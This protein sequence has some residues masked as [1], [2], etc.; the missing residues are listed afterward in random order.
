[1]SIQGGKSI[2]GLTALNPLVGTEDFVVRSA[3]Q[4]FRVNY[5]TLL[6]K[7]SGDLTVSNTMTNEG[8]LIYFTTGANTRLPIGT[9]NQFLR[10]SSGL[11]IW[12]T[13][14]I[15]TNPTTFQGD[16]I[17]NE[18]GELQ[19]V[20]IGSAGQVLTVGVTG[21]PEWTDRTSYED[22]LTTTGDILIRGDVITERLAAGVEGQ[23]LTMADGKPAWET[24]SNTILFANGDLLTHNGDV[25]VVLGIGTEGQFLTVENSLPAW[26][27]VT[28]Y[29]DPLTTNGD[30]VARI[31]GVTTRLG[32]GTAGQV[33]ASTG[34][35]PEWQD[36]SSAILI[37]DLLPISPTASNPSAG[38]DGQVIF[39][40]ETVG[41]Y[42]LKDEAGA[43]RIFTNG[44]S[45]VN[46]VVSIGGTT[47]D[48]IEL[49]LNQSN[50]LQLEQ[51]TN[52][53]LE[54]GWTGSY[55]SKIEASPTFIE[56]LH[57]GSYGS[58]ARYSITMNSSTK[59]ML[60]TDGVNARGIEYAADY[61]SKFTNETLVTRRYVNNEFNRIIPMSVTALNPGAGQ[62]GYVL[63]WDN[64]NEVFDLKADAG[65]A[66]SVSI[67]GTPLNNQLAVWTSASQIEGDANLLWNGGSLDITGDLNVDGITISGQSISS[68]G[69]LILSPAGGIVEI[70]NVTWNVGQSLGPAQDGYVLTYDD[71]TGTAFFD[72]VGGGGAVS[73]AGTPSANEIAV[74]TNS[75]TI[76]GSTGF[77]FDA[78][79][80]VLSIGNVKIDND[81]IRVGLGVNTLTLNLTGGLSESLS[82]GAFI[83]L[84]GATAASSR[85]VAIH[86]STIDFRIGTSGVGSVSASVDSGGDWNF[87]SNNIS[88]VGVLST[89][90]L[91]IGDSGSLSES[92]GKLQ[93]FHP[94]GIVLN[95]DGNLGIDFSN[96]T[97]FNIDSIS[98]GSLSLRPGEVTTSGGNLVIGSLTGVVE[99][100]ENTLNIGDTANSST[101]VIQAAGSTATNN[102]SIQPKGSGNVSIGNYTFDGDQ[103]VGA[104]QDGYTMTYSNSTGLVSLSAQNTIG[105]PTSVLDG[106]GVT[107][108]AGLNMDGFTGATR[109]FTYQRI[110]N[111]VHFNGTAG[112][113]P[114]ATGL[115]NFFI[116]MP[117]SSNFSQTYDAGGVCTAKGSVASG[118][119]EAT[120]DDRLEV[121]INLDSTT[122]QVVH[123][124]GFYIVK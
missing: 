101:A 95:G 44:L 121:G 42:Q 98:I 76:E 45:E 48:D 79:S 15:L 36:V 58:G 32:I 3:S 18:G 12:E 6:S 8:D 84:A 105:T 62:D 81:L 64:S 83:S 31:G 74:W 23:V 41:E 11:P 16:I 86:G 54:V 100:R 37:G 29:N 40:N 56:L 34:S 87:S 118:Y 33:L 24:P 26:N 96:E 109:V 92:S 77:E 94:G 13:V 35:L 71:T 112:V 69:N 116:D 51:S 50:A 75:T 39:W 107:F 49:N 90:F 108:T 97:L 60:I 7:I 25:E 78:A 102:I 124:S 113:D 93:I 114:S 89:D 52:V 67:G 10:V 123:F 5:S 122:P 68:S 21:L 55:Q 22:P 47:T 111:I 119:V 91:N 70:D 57:S 72:T 80:D 85:N 88:G 14:D 65:G 43:S 59:R 104:G 38:N 115:A 2:S 99:V 73:I 27:D 28:I 106:A 66:G 46:N 120:P 20:P 110:G 61:S 1:M 117:V 63:F 19:R 82:D 17:T 30:L 53:N 9:E 103:S 4:N